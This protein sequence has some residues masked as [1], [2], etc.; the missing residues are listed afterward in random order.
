[1]IV[2]LGNIIFWIY[3]VALVYVTLYCLVQFHLLVHYK[4]HHWKRD[5]LDKPT[6]LSN[7][8]SPLVTVQLPIYNEQYVTERLIDNIM[9]LDYP[10]EKLEVH[11]LD[12]STDETVDIS[13]RKVAEYKAKGF[14]IELITRKDRSGYKAGALKAA[15]PK[16]SGDLIAIFDADFLPYKDFL[17][18]TVPYFNNPEIGVVQTRWEHINKD[19]SLLTRLQAFQLNV[20][21]TIEQQGRESGNLLLQFNGTAGLWRKKTIEDAGGW[22]ADTLTEDLD[23]SYRAQIKGWKIAFLE[24][25]GAPAELPAEMHGLKSQQHRWMKGGAETARKMLPTVWKSDLPLHQKLHGSAHLLASSVFLCVFIIGVFSVPLLFLITPIGIDMDNLMIF[26]ISLVSLV[27]V[28]LQA[29]VF[30]NWEEENRLWKVFKFILIFPLF[31][32]ISMG[33]A[34]H[35]SL[36]VMQGFLGKKSAFI[37]T[38]KYKLEGKSDSFLNKNYLDI[39]LNKGIIMEG[40]LTLYFLFALIAGFVIEDGSFFVFHFFLT[41]GYGFI[42]FYS[43]KHLKY[44]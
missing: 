41:L 3:I 36:A 20:H 10:K 8:E 32:A 19:Y 18:K 29:N 12:D 2:V 37:R 5:K 17:R 43:V 31:L 9:L 14:N 16:A 22:E 4:M 11:I 42:F 24:D 23:L 40:F 33:L 26:L 34:F 21:F 27:F 39:R 13:R 1:M 30:T 7:D 35:N 38:P 28:Y 15:T 44:K 25:I 6:A